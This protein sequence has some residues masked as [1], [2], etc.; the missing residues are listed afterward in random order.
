VHPSAS[1]LVAFLVAALYPPLSFQL[2]PRRWATVNKGAQTSLPP[3][4]CRTLQVPA[5]EEA[6]AAEADLLDWSEMEGG[7]WPFLRLANQLCAD[8]VDHQW[9][10]RPE[11]L[12]LLEASSS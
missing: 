7:R 8:V 12:P 6:A 11:S 5:A 2:R 10:V 9:E 3:P 1:V 4:P